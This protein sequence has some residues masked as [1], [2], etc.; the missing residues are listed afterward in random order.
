[1]FFLLVYCGG[2]WLTPNAWKHGTGERTV[3]LVLSVHKWKRRKISSMLL[4]ARWRSSAVCDYETTY[5]TWLWAATLWGLS[6]YWADGC[7]K[8][9]KLLAVVAQSGKGFSGNLRTCTF[10][11]YSPVQG[12]ILHRTWIGND[13]QAN[14][15]TCFGWI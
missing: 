3:I 12:C 8:G 11:S 9:R 5:S 6:S 10:Y 13:N 1:M 14:Y 4:N 2:R 15:K 7:R